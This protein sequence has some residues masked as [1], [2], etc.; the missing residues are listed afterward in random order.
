MVF[1]LFFYCVTVQTKNVVITTFNHRQTSRP[2]NR[3]RDR[4]T[5]F[6]ERRNRQNSIL[7]YLTP[8]KP[9]NE[10][11]HSQKLQNSPQLMIPKLNTYFFYHH[12][13]HSNATIG[14]FLVR[15]AFKSDN[16][17]ETFTCKRT[18]CKTCPFYLKH[19]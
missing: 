17:P 6:T 4:T 19:S 1:E 8:T 15:N 16:Q 7:P 5:D 2:R 12:S 9:C 18:R 10:K 14:N 11:C 3:P 13:F